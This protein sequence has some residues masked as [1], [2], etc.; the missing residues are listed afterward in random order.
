MLDLFRR[1]FGVE[2][3]SRVLYSLS[4]FGDAEG[5]PMP[6]MLV[7]P[8]WEQMKADIRAWVRAVAATPGPDR[9]Y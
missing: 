6:Q 8:T 9:T 5:D 3:I 1:K 7:P 2:D 4:Y